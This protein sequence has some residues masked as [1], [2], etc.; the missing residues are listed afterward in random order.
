MLWTLLLLLLLLVH[1]HAC[2]TAWAAVGRRAGSTVS[3]V[4]TKSTAA[5][6]TSFQSDPLQLKAVLCP[7]SPW[8]GKEPL[9]STNVSTPRLQRSTAL[10][11]PMPPGRCCSCNIS[12]A[13]Y[14]G[15]PQ[16]VRRPS[17]PIF[18]AKPKSVSFT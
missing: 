3:R 8:K 18:L 17:P 2:C 4:Q 16:K 14:C 6:D 12:G 7:F 15:V 13:K 11:Y 10:V 5:A 9:S 1:I